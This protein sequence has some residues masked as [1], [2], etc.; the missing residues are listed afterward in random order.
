MLQCA[1]VNQFWGN[2]LIF[3]NILRDNTCFPM[4]QPLPIRKVFCALQT[5]ERKFVI[6]VTGNAKAAQQSEQE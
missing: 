3:E 5:G 4:Q 1:F 2:W 6:P